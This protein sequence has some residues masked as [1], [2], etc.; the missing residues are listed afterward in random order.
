MHSYI[1]IYIHIHIHMLQLTE[2]STELEFA[3]SIAQ[4]DEKLEMAHAMNEPIDVVTEEIAQVAELATLVVAKLPDAES[5][6]ADLERRVTELKADVAATTEKL[7]ARKET[8]TLNE[9]LR[10]KVRRKSGWTI[11][12]HR[13]TKYRHKELGQSSEYRMSTE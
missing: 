6:A 1:Y 12:I 9:V 13:Y 2:K 4:I 8:E 3:L 7:L 11:S 5:D 10:H